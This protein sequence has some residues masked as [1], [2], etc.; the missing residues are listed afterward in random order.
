MSSTTSAGAW[1]VGFSSSTG[2]DEVPRESIWKVTFRRA[3][4]AA[5]ANKKP[6]LQLG[7]SGSTHK[8][9]L[10]A[11]LNYTYHPGLLSAENITS[12]LHALEYF[13][14][15]GTQ[16]LSVLKFHTKPRIMRYNFD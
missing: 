7:I 6:Q 9:L 14:L 1:L 5:P 8:S 16:M 13:G 3:S 10:K 15:V 4:V 11:P 2:G 12:Y